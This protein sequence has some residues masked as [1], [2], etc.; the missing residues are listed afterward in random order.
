MTDEELN[1]RFDQL[2]EGIR[3]S[4]ART[5]ETIKDSEARTLETMRDMQTEI[6]RG[7][8]RFARGNF[9]RMHRLEVSDNDLNERLNAL[10]ERITAIET[11]PPR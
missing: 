2:H 9:S 7:L 3:D 4:E 11:R 1:R 5:L 8:E 6:L 10:E